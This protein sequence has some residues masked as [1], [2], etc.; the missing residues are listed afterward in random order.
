M[1][2]NSPSSQ[3][4][5]WN[6]IAVVLVAFAAIVGIVLAIV[7]VARNARRII[8][9]EPVVRHTTV[10]ADA[11]FAAFRRDLRRRLV[12]VKRRFDKHYPASTP[13]SPEQESLAQRCIIGFRRMEEICASLDTFRAARNA[14]PHQRLAMQEYRQLLED[15]RN[16]ARSLTKTEFPDL[17]SLDREL[18]KLISE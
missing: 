13:L 3:K 18:R 14:E 8:L 12:K 5:R 16:L 17:D 11:K 7:V 4:Y 15:V 1:T 6:R 2:I 9:P 10:S